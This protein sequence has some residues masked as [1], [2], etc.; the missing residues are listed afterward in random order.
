MNYV[1]QTRV[2]AVGNVKMQAGVEA[3]RLRPPERLPNLRVEMEVVVA[4]AL[5]PVPVMSVTIVLLTL[6]VPQV[7]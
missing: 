2:N 1:I 4:E 5:L 3:V 6:K 7:S